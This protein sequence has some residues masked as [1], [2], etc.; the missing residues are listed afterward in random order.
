M[1]ILHRAIELRVVYGIASAY[2]ER[3]VVDQY[4][5]RYLFCLWTNVHHVA[6]KTLVMIFPQPQSKLSRLTRCILSQIL[7]FRDYFSFFLGGGRRP[8]SGVG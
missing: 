8:R 1:F 5:H 2:T 3:A 6:W 4:L 7:N